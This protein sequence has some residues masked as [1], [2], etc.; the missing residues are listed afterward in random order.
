MQALKELRLDLRHM[1]EVGLLAF[2][3]KHRANP[4]SAEY[5]EAQAEWKRRQ[6]KKAEIP[7]PQP[8][9]PTSGEFGQM[10]KAAG[11]RYPRVWYPDARR[12]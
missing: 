3:C 9:V 10:A 7:K 6:K 2:C 1:D 5:L 4:D 8:V 12:A 11:D